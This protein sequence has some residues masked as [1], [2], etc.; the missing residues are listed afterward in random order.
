MGFN[1]DEIPYLFNEVRSFRGSSM[2]RCL[3]NT[4]SSYVFVFFTAALA[5][6]I[7]SSKF[8]SPMT[9][10]FDTSESLHIL[11]ASS[12]A[13]AILRYIT[14]MPDDSHRP[15]L[16]FQNS[17]LKKKIPSHLVHEVY[18]CVHRHVVPLLVLHLPFPLVNTF[19]VIL[20]AKKPFQL[21]KWHRPELL[22]SS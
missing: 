20:F 19:L 16:E 11:I 21:F 9:P 1:I 18:E 2:A 5:R 15:K 4:V 12:C 6:A 8:P 13:F 7:R 14:K 10:F 17:K 3:N 22:D